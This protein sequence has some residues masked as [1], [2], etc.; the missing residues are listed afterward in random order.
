MFYLAF[1]ILF[2]VQKL[3]SY[4]FTLPTNGININ[5]DVVCFRN[6]EKNFLV[7][8]TICLYSTEGGAKKG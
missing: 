8:L 1:Q 4:P 7:S 3:S 2:G 6:L 5:Q